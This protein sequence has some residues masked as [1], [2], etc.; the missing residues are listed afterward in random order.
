[1]CLSVWLAAFDPD[2]FEPC[3]RDVYSKHTAK[4]AGASLKAAAGIMDAAEGEATTG[5]GMRAGAITSCGAKRG[6]VPVNTSRMERA[7]TKLLLSFPKLL[8]SILDVL[9]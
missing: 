4:V 7:N 9:I 5:A 3:L 8:L 6:R 2:L 1:M